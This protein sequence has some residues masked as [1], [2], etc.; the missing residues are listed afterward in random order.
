MSNT[1]NKAKILKAMKLDSVPDFKTIDEVCKF[2]TSHMIERYNLLHA[3]EINCGYCFIWALYVW[4]LWKD[5]GKI[6]FFST[7][8]HVFLKVGRLYYD[9]NHSGAKYRAQITC[10]HME[11]LNLLQMVWYWAQRGRQKKK[12][13]GLLNHIAPKVLRDVKPHFYSEEWHADNSLPVDEALMA[14]PKRMNA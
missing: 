1:L 10:M 14:L 4:A 2:V 5:N 6:K 7:S 9:S 13:V 11:K 8:S 3:G 12:F